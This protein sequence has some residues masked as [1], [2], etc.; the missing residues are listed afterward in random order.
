[1][2]MNLPNNREFANEFYEDCKSLYIAKGYSE[3]T[4]INNLILQLLLISGYILIEDLNRGHITEKV[5]REVLAAAKS[6]VLRYYNET[7]MGKPT[8]TDPDIKKKANNRKK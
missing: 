1:Q 2:L 7:K 8:K 6:A 5:N 4:M 3:E